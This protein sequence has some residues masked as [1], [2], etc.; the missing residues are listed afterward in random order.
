MQRRNAAKKTN[1]IHRARSPIHTTFEPL[2][3]PFFW[4]TLPEIELNE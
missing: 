3:P 4:H 1:N 2:N